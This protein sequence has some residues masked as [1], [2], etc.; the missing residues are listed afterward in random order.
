LS[1]ARGLHRPHDFLKIPHAL[2]QE[3]EETCKIHAEPRYV[4]DV[5][6]FMIFPVNHMVIFGYTSFIALLLA[7][8]KLASN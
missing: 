5:V 6:Q 7:P 8:F 4:T 1:I 3:N 2:V